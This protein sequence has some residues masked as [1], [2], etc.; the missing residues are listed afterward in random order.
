MNETNCLIA[1]LIVGFRE[2]HYYYCKPYTLASITSAFANINA[3]RK[4]LK[5]KRNNRPYTQNLGFLNNFSLKEIFASLGDMLLYVVVIE[6][7][8]RGEYRIY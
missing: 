5:M 6:V 1:K 2:S 3:T 4:I 8:V 7:D